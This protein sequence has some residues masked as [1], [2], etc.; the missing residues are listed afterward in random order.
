MLK[1]WENLGKNWD[2]TSFKTVVNFSTRPNKVEKLIQ[3]I[4]D[5]EKAWNMMKTIYWQD[6]FLFTYD[7]WKSADV[8]TNFSDL[9]YNS[10]DFKS[11]ITIAIEF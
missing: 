8:N 9:E 3:L 1:K 10:N 7:I 2:S 4:V 6:R 5:K 11:S